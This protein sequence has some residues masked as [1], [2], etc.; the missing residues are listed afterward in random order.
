MVISVSLPQNSMI[1]NKVVE[2][3]AALKAAVCFSLFAF[4]FNRLRAPSPQP[5]TAAITRP[6][7]RQTSSTGF[8][9]KFI[10]TSYTD[11][12]RLRTSAYR[13]TSLLQINFD[14]PPTLQGNHS[15]G[16][17]RR[18]GG[19][20]S[21][22]RRQHSAD[23]AAR[24]ERQLRVRNCRQTLGWVGKHKRMWRAESPPQTDCLGSLNTCALARLIRFCFAARRFSLCF[25]PPNFAAAADFRRADNR[26]TSRRFVF[27]SFPK[28]ARVRERDFQ[29]LPP[30]FVPVRNLVDAQMCDIPPPFL[31]LFLPFVN[32]ENV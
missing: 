28:I 15:G 22:L 23:A 26:P 17:G 9:Q 27:P 18:M 24:N 13:P 19:V 32:S 8:I 10:R 4:S 6:R 20:H 16:W 14:F 2:R 31:F 30:L 5:I 7:A 1:R 12:A 3:T 29:F 21:A 11:G 25:F